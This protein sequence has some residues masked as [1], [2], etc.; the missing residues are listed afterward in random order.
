VLIVAISPQAK[1]Y[2]KEPICILY[3]VTLEMPKS[4][5]GVA[6]AVKMNSTTANSM[7]VRVINKDTDEDTDNV[8]EFAD[9]LGVASSALPVDNAYKQLIPEGCLCQVD[10][11]KACDMFG[12]N[13]SEDRDFDAV[14][15]KKTL[16]NTFQEIQKHR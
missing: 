8:E 2:S 10:I 5:C 14:I 15:S 16:E 12:F 11:K 1:K 6:N 4:L 7:C 3:K 9:M 13:Y